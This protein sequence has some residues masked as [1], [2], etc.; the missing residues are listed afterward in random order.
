MTNPAK[1]IY[2]PREVSEMLGV[3]L[4][5]LRF[6]EDSF[7]QLKPERTPAGHRRYRQRDIDVCKAIISLI[8]YK[9]MSIEY[10]QKAMESYRKYPPRQPRKCT[11]TAEAIAL[12]DEVRNATE[13]PHMV[14]AI[15]SVKDWIKSLD[16]P[17]IHNNIRGKEYFTNTSEEIK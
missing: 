2:R 8:R 1:S 10:A 12:L 3:P 16:A 15:D 5:T 4:S 9:G 14:S 11:S 13:D 7:P 6:W 17:I